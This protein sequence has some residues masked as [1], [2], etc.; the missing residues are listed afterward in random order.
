MTRA[1]IVEQSS[2]TEADLDRIEGVVTA[3]VEGWIDFAKSSPMPDASKA[4]A[5]VYV[6]WEVAA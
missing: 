4:T 2:L 6:G 5:N 3:E 1:K